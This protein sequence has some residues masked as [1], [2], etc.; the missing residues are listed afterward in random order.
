M[1][2]VRQSYRRRF[3]C[4]RKVVAYKSD[5]GV[6]AFAQQAFA[7]WFWLMIFGFLGGLMWFFSTPTGK[8]TLREPGQVSEYQQRTGV[9]DQ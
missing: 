1:L 2:L 5:R 8:K 4:E 3:L 9:M 7:F 6:G